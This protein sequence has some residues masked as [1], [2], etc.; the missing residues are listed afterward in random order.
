MVGEIPPKILPVS[1][2]HP[3]VKGIEARFHRRPAP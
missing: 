2:F 1:E 3:V